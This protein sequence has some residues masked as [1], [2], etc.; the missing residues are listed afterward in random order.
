MENYRQQM[1]SRYNRRA[2]MYQNI[3]CGCGDRLN[4][5]TAK[6]E[7]D[8]EHDHDHEY[9]VLAERCL[10]R[11]PL[12]M[13]YVPFQ[14]WENVVDAATGLA[15]GSIFMDLVLPFYGDKNCYGMRGDRS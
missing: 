2:G 11:L 6:R 14:K 13:T 12:G 15:H 3:P 7:H 8:H 5:D 4:M 10:D 1:Y 9:E